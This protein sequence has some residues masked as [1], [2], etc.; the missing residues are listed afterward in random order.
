MGK[1]INYKQAQKNNRRN[2]EDEDRVP[3]KCWMNIGTVKT[4]K[5]P[6][7][8]ELVDKL[9]ALVSGIPL[10]T[11]PDAKRKDAF[12]QAQNGLRDKLV[13]KAMSLEPGEALLSDDSIWG[14]RIEIR[15]VR[16]NEEI[17]LGENPFE[18][19]LDFG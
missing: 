15:R 2:V 3:A 6:E 4:V 19:E 9:T 16:E 1:V 5:D 17:P 11:M 8:G 13:K 18:S 10:D 14:L 12:G 7:T